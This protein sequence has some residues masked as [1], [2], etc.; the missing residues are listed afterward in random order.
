MLLDPYSILNEA[1]FHDGVD[2]PNHVVGSRNQECFGKYQLRSTE[3][4]KLD[5]TMHTVLYFAFL[6]LSGTM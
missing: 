4:T 3:K 2:F 1:K 5:Y 6:L